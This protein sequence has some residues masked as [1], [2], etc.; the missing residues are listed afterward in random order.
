M[1][2]NNI[3]TINIISDSLLKNNIGGPLKV[4]NNTLLGF[5]LIGQKFTVNQPL[6]RN[7]FNW[8]HDSIKY[9]IK[10]AILNKPLLVGPNLFVL[11]EE[12]PI[13]SDYSNI[14]YLHPSQWAKDIWEKR[15]FNNCRIEVWPAGIDT[16]SFKMIK[17]SPSKDVLFYF[18]NRN[19]QL[20]LEVLSLLE[21]FGLNVILIEYG[22]YNE[23]EFKEALRKSYFGIWVG[24]TESQGIGLL[25]ALASNLPL[26]VLESNNIL[27]NTS[28]RLGDYPSDLSNHIASS[29]PY[30]D[31]RCGYVINS[32][33]ELE[34]KIND[35]ISNYEIFDPSSYVSDNLSL[36]L[37]A[38]KLVSLFDELEEY[39]IP[40]HNIFSSN[41]YNIKSHYIYYNFVLRKKIR[42]A[43]KLLI[44]SL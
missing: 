6:K 24:T 4:I 15:G 19:P 12:I 32:I 25:E 35:I 20:K 42:T 11:P 33:D 23:I 14:I 30:F 13:R 10:A 9:F 3:I 26:I 17:R 44:N 38:S 22:N 29:A 34:I 39:N 40:N 8:I 16:N 31:R 36:A 2:Q 1:G 28:I 5:E 18:K 37:S 27:D 41:Y 7:Q 21:K 43:K